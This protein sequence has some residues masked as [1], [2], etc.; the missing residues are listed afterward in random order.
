MKMKHSVTFVLFFVVLLSCLNSSALAAGGSIWING[1]DT[2]TNSQSV[3]LLLDAC[4]YDICL[5]YIGMQGV[6]SMRFSNDGFIWS[7]PEPAAVSKT[8]TL[9]PGYGT[10]TVYV[11]YMATTGFWFGPYNDTIFYTDAPDYFSFS[12]QYSVLLNTLLYSNTVT[13]S[14]MINPQTISVSGGEYSIDGGPFTSA[15]GTI[16][17]GSTVQV[18]Q[19]S[20]P[21]FHITTQ[22]TLDIGGVSSTFSVTTRY[23]DTTPD[24]FT[25]DP[26][27]NMSLNTVVT[28]NAVTISGIEATAYISVSGGQYSINGGAFTSAIGTVINGDTVEV[29]QTSSANNATTTNAVLT[30]GG[31]SGT[32]SVTTAAANSPLSVGYGPQ[33]LLI[34]FISLM[35]AGGY[36]AYR[37]V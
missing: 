20:S 11:K 27:N 15:S 5:T 34:T 28:S 30:V 26:Q 1:S 33:G 12:S 24:S 6:S 14:G 3:T 37:R 23:A 18:R 10:K 22:T 32:F 21:S 7:N 8:W 17:N 2:V 19:T 13:I 25:L 35:L 16:Y 29:R 9:T 36:L 31:V 4:S